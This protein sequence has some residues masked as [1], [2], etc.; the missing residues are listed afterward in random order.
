MSKLTLK[1]SYRSIQMLNKEP[2]VNAFCVITVEPEYYSKLDIFLK[3]KK[4]PV[5][6]ENPQLV[7]ESDVSQ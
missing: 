5:S 2:K 3:R 6:H 1:T 4:Q 7:I